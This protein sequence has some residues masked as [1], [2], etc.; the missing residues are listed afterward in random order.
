VSRTRRVSSSRSR[1][2]G[3]HPPPDGEPAAACTRGARRRRLQQVRVPGLPCRAG[4]RRRGHAWGERAA[5]QSPTKVKYYYRHKEARK[6]KETRFAS[7]VPYRKLLY[8]K[9][10]QLLTSYGRLARL[11]GRGPPEG[12]PAEVGAG[13]VLTPQRGAGPRPGQRGARR[14]ARAVARRQRR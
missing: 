13:A 6:S 9:C 10:P 2:R 4:L 3:I 12:R 11:R 1:R 14:S 7:I 5:G 8:N